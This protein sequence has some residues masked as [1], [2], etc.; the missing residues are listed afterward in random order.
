MI[1]D[2]LSEAVIEIEQYLKDDQ[3]MYP[4][5]SATLIVEAIDAMN[6]AREDLDIVI[7]KTVDIH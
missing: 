1:S 6:R 4:K 7:S 3:F 5:E 2:I